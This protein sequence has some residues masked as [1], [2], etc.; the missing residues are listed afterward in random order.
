[1]L[2]RYFCNVCLV[3]SV[4]SSQCCCSFLACRA[5][6]ILSVL[7]YVVL[8][9]LLLSG[10]G[11]GKSLKVLSCLIFSLFVF[12]CHWLSC[13]LLHCYCV[14]GFL[15]KSCLVLSSL[16]LSCLVVI[17][18]FLFSSCIYI[19]LLFLF[20]AHPSIFLSIFGRWNSCV[21]WLLF[22]SLKFMCFLLVLSCVMLFCFVLSSLLFL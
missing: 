3:L 7:F 15:F 10:M 16:L 2:S 20:F 19:V 17:Y 6:L 22:L 12:S 18:C 5:C 8:S 13:V 1:M 9:C 14:V 11:G 21:G 4:L